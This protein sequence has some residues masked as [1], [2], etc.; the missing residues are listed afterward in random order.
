MKALVSTAPLA[1]ASWLGALGRN[2]P[3]LDSTVVE[4]FLAHLSDIGVKET[5]APEDDPLHRLLPGAA[6]L[7]ADLEPGPGEPVLV[8]LIT[9]PARMDPDGLQRSLRESGARRVMVLSA[10]GGRSSLPRVALNPAGRPCLVQ[11][12]DHPEPVTNLRDTGLRMAWG[13]VAGEA[14]RAG[15][16]SPA[17]AA[18]DGT[19]ADTTSCG[20][21]RDILSP[22]SYLMCCHEMLTG[23]AVD[24]YGPSG[25]APGSVIHPDAVLESAPG[26]NVWLAE[27]VSVGKDTTL[28]RTVALRGADVGSG[29]RLDSVL[30]LPGA[31]VPD[32]TDLSDKYLDI[33]GMEG[34]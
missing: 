5:A 10:A 6:G 14:L 25:T 1:A 32:G 16:G 11:G 30:V 34:G 17:L 3:L 2:P 12:P 15:L 7:V 19:L 23:A 22:E 27:G 24:W 13:S 28:S 4:D 26:E 33:I 8:A 21:H 29:C 9:G 31:R 18:G 20:Y